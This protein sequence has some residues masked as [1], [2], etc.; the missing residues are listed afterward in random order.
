[1][2]LIDL[3]SGTVIANN[4]RVGIIRFDDDG[5]YRVHFTHDEPRVV[6][7]KYLEGSNW[8]LLTAQPVGEAVRY[9]EITLEEVKGGDLLH[10]EFKDGPFKNWVQQIGGDGRLGS[11]PKAINR[12]FR[13]H[14]MPPL[15]ALP[16]REPSLD[17]D[18]L[19]AIDY[20]LTCVENRTM[21]ASVAMEKLHAVPQIAALLEE[22]K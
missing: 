1:M 14:N 9:E 10:I 7:L 17:P 19:L 18:P 5:V 15:P 12:I 20:V 13:I 21:T 22:T 4:Y 2:R 6:E 11:C 3:P 8:Q 16:P